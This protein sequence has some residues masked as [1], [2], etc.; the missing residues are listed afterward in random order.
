M[1]KSYCSC[2]SYI[3]SRH[4]YSEYPLW[5]TYVKISDNEIISP[6]SHRNTDSDFSAIRDTGITRALIKAGS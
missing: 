4:K 6:I 5:H 3:Y 2:Y 1:Y